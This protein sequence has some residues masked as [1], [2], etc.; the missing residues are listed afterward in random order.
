MKNEKRQSKITRLMGLLLF[1]VFALCVLGVLLT[2]AEVYGG[3]R[4]RGESAYNGRTAAR[5][6]STRVHQSDSLDGVSV[7]DFGG[8]DALVIREEA[9]GEI[10]ETRVYCREGWLME[11]FALQGSGLGPEDGERLLELRSLELLRS[12][13]LI[14]AELVGEDGSVES[15]SLFLRSGGEGQP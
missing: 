11:L 14:T 6:I 4:Q 12:D 3:L 7:E 5:Y 15:L 10:Y 1:A 13:D 2:G 8:C 9:E